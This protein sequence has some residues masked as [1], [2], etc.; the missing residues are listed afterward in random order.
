M[1]FYKTPN[2]MATP[3]EAML[4]CAVYVAFCIAHTTIHSPGVSI[5]HVINGK[6]SLVSKAT[7]LHWPMRSLF[8][9][10][11]SNKVSQK[12]EALLIGQHGHVVSLTNECLILQALWW[13]LTAGLCIVVCSGWIA[14]LATRDIMNTLC[15]GA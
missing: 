13:I 9:A 15:S 8:Q 10:S 2:V 5:H 14:T 3:P 12:K 1:P 7:W 6:R 4:P 11:S